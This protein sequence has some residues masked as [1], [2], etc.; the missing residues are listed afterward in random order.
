MSPRGHMSRRFDSSID[1]SCRS[2]D[3]S[4]FPKKARLRQSDRIGRDGDRKRG[5][6]D[7]ATLKIM[8]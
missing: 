4:D 6:S 8:S 3:I 2:V 5:D 1:I 7:R